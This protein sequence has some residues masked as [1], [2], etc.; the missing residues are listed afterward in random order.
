MRF[1]CF[2]M[3]GIFM[4]WAGSGWI[5]GNE[6][7]F[8]SQKRK[9]GFL[10]ELEKL[11]SRYDTKERMIARPFSSPGYHTQ[12]KG[13]TVHPT[14]DSLRYAVALFDSG[15]HERIERGKKIMERVIDLQDQDPARK[16]YGIWSW[17]LEEPLDRMAPPDWNW[18][19][20]CGALLLQIALDH[21]DRLSA[22]LQEKLKDS[23]IH[24]CRSIKRRNVGPGY[25]NIAL[26]G[27]Y[28]THTAG[29]LFN[30]PEFLAYG[31]AR[32][33]R[34]YDYTLKQGSFSEYNSPTY[35]VVA[36][37]EISR[38][39]L[40]IRDADSQKLI[41][42]LNRRAWR[43]AARRFHPPTGQWAGPHSRCYSTFIR[44][45]T[46]GF[47]ERATGF[48]AGLV[49]QEIA[50]RSLFAHRIGARCP[51]EFTGFFTKL[52][53]PRLEREVF[54]KRGT[55]RNDII[56]TTWLDRDYTI[57]SL[58]CGDL[59]NQ[60][61]PLLGYF[62]T[63]E[64][65]AAFRI[66]CLH[67]GYDYSSAGLFTV[68]EKHD[69]LGAVVFATDRG[70]THISLD[71]L[72]DGAIEAEDLR[73]RFQVTGKVAGCR[74]P[75]GCS[76]GKA[77]QFKLGTADLHLK[78]CKAAFGAEEAV[79]ET[80]KGGDGNAGFIADVVLYRGKKKQLPFKS[81]TPA[82]VVFAL[83][84]GEEKSV[85]LSGVTVRTDKTKQFLHAVWKRNGKPDMQLTVPVKPLRTGEQMKAANA[86]VGG[87]D[88][89]KGES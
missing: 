3:A 22:P 85:D 16:T 50:C 66:R 20:F 68:Q 21:T 75:A 81:I 8:G 37:R 77:L 59:W 15:E 61:R 1:K 27:T 35:T 26:M 49:S 63:P 5:R 12:L 64:G 84:T 87:A 19:D 73:V 82:F 65:V 46:L 58:N 36:I 2:L 79:L 32:L 45:S 34:F 33:Q 74:L 48:K 57:A 60:R 78:L 71:R 7:L 14:R 47:I 88:P 28:V 54:R 55:G 51:T 17:F 86:A 80:Q 76:I 42:E 29:E 4:A 31:K 72:R 83:S 52:A 13:G 44:S 62:K 10:H 69:I 39:M 24:A 38:M 30:L 11:D 70:D 23:I 40:H 89:W 67:D 25:T 43:H 18:A 6:P 9:K 56:G 53:S 41:K